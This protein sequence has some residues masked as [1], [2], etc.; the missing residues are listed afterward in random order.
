MPVGF[1]DTIKAFVN[2]KDEKKRRVKKKGDNEAD[3]YKGES[4]VNYKYLM[5][6]A[7]G[8]RPPYPPWWDCDKV[9]KQYQNC[10]N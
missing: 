10:R 8:T 6:F 4:G 2:Y 1:M 5:G 3:G 9:S 7:D